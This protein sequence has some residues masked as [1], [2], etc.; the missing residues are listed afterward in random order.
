MTLSALLLGLSLGAYAQDEDEV[1]DVPV[2]DDAPEVFVPSTPV[3]KKFFQRVQLGYTGTIT[4]YTNFG[5]SPDYNNY[6]LHGIGV[7]WMGDLRIAKKI[8]LYL[9]L[10]VNLTY[11]FG[12]SKGDSILTY[13][14]S[15]GGDEHV[16]SYKINAFS[17][18]IPVNI[19]KQFKNAFGVED[20]TI[21]PFAGVYARFNLMAKRKETEKVTYYTYREDGGRDVR[22]T[23]DGNPM[24]EKFKY[25]ASLM[26]V[27][28]DKR[29]IIDKPHTGKLLQCGAQAGVNVFYKNYSLGVAYMRDLMPFAGHVSSK[30]LTHKTTPQG[31]YL[32]TIGTNCDE[33]ITTDNNF[34]VTVGYV[35]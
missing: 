13:P 11:H 23:E 19:S 4:K 5:L 24:V 21:A 3:D 20:L 14:A 29:A 30:E 32:P 18:T 31:G 8:D 22:Y 25:S 7:G 15:Q 12:N 26:K 33:K 35:F 34:M 10:G 28:P 27:D 16:H 6:F 9:E 2:D 17:L 1:L